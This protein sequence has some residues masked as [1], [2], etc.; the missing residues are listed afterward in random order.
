M[1]FLNKENAGHYQ[2]IIKYV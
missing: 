2:D 1:P